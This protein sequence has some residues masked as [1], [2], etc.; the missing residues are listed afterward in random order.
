MAQA[1]GVVA[2]G[3]GSAVRSDINGQYAAL[4]SN[5][6][7]STEP[8]SGKVAHQF[9]ADTNTNIFKIRN[10]ANNAWINLFTLAGGIDVDAAS[11]F[12]G[13]ITVAADLNL[14]QSSG[15]TNYIQWDNSEGKFK[16]KDDIKIT[17]GD[18]EDL[19]IYHSGDWNYMQNHNSKNIAIQVNGTEN[20]LIAL[21][22]SA[23]KLYFDGD[24]KLET[25]ADGCK[26]S[27]D[28]SYQ[29]TLNRSG[30]A[31]Q[32]AGLLF[33]DGTDEYARIISYSGN[34]NID[35]GVGSGAYDNAIHC[36]KDAAVIFYYN[37]VEKCRTGSAGLL[38]NRTSNDGS[39][40]LQVAE[41]GSAGLSVAT[42]TTSERTMCEFKNSN[43]L[44]GLISVVNSQ[45]NYNTSSDYRLKENEV[46]IS[47]GITRL[48]TLKPYR[49]NFK[50]DPNATVD[51]FFAH[52]VTAVPEAVTGEKDGTDMQ[53][54]DYGRITPLL[55][56]ALQELLGR[57]E[58]LENA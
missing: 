41:T 36:Q 16:L 17:S 57:V 14:R 3:T 44:V 47:D 49:F 10:A 25:T 52:E 18:S 1:D 28:G 37:H 5:H 51:G 21:P 58:K 46:A 45:T 9:W 43:G 32:Q 31:T 55:T 23:V 4:W 22:N 26:I 19:I 30:S 38:V 13:D 39:A 42:G 24:A 29:L 54:M 6:S 50:T 33:L 15:A 27:D 7:G 48:K 56:A 11:T 2:N 8:S 12:N 35:V 53:G 20:A 40:P 34:L